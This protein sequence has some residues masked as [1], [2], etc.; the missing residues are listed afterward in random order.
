MLFRIMFLPLA[1]YQSIWV[2]EVSHKAL[3]RRKW[4]VEG[5]GQNGGI[6]SRIY[7][8][9]KV[10]WEGEIDSFTGIL[11]YF[12]SIFSGTMFGDVYLIGQFSR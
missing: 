4:R 12:A 8:N 10:V 3:V 2:N 5:R 1:K 11:Y 9:N 6:L 7:F